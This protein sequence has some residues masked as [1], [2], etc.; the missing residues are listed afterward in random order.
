[1]YLN[2][3]CDLQNLLTS[4]LSL[5]NVSGRV[6]DLFCCSLCMNRHVTSG[7]EETADGGIQA[8]C[9]ICQTPGS[10]EQT[11]PQCCNITRRGRP[12]SHY[13]GSCFIIYLMLC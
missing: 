7:P 4:Y 12:W 1:M 2:R 8:L 6:H 10:R 5:L 3:S 9:H 13:S 11:P